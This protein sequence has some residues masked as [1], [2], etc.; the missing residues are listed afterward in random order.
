MLRETSL[1]EVSL[2]VAAKGMQCN[3]M[4][5]IKF[6]LVIHFIHKPKPTVFVIGSVT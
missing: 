4:I 6:L 5:S 3:Y 2:E 1:K